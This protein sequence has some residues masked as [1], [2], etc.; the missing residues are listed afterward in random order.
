MIGDDHDLATRVISADALRGGDPVHRFHLDVHQDNG[1]PVVTKKGDRFLTV[2]RSSI[3]EA[4]E[5][6]GKMLM[7]KIAHP[8]RTLQHIMQPQFLAGASTAEP[9]R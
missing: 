5:T 9:S 8:D 2:V 6:L 7:E 3:Q 1:W 4:G